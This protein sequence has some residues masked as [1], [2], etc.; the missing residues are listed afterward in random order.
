MKYF[1]IL[2]LLVL[3]SGCTSVT[4][5]IYPT[6][7]LDTLKTGNALIIVERKEENA[8]SANLVEVSENG[9]V[10]GQLGVGI[11]IK[12]KRKYHQ[13]VWERPAG[14]MRLELTPSFIVK[15]ASP[16]VENV[17]AGKTYT[18]VV[19]FKYSPYGLSWIEK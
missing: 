6:A 9:T 7:T 17:E 4:E 8:A 10:V 2:F 19:G 16:I 13:L 18:Y 15:N 1:V 3:I 12:D 5:Q 14:P 11:K